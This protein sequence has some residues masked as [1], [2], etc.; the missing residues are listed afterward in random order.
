MADVTVWM[1]CFRFLIALGRVIHEVRVNHRNHGLDVLANRGGVPS[2][3]ESFDGMSKCGV[4]VAQG[5]ENQA[6]E[7]LDLWGRSDWS[8]RRLHRL[9][10]LS[11]QTGVA[12]QGG[13]EP[14]E[15]LPSTVFKTA[16]LNRSAISP[17]Q[18]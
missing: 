4:L 6:G 17:P 12:E 18:R 2:S 5:K 3:I 9:E 11:D 15:V 13:F 16:A 8:E 14:P 7:H 10:G 1:N